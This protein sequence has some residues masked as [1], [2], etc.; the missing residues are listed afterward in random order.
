MLNRYRNYFTKNVRKYIEKNLY[1]LYPEK[2]I[3]RNLRN[4]SSQECERFRNSPIEYLSSKESL[5]IALYFSLGKEQTNFNEKVF[6]DVMD[7]FDYSLKLSTCPK[8]RHLIKLSIG[9]VLFEKGVHVEKERQRKYL[10]LAKYYLEESLATNQNEELLFIYLTLVEVSLGHLNVAIKN[11]TK[12]SKASENPL[13]IWR[14]LASI[15]KNLGMIS[16][17]DYFL[18]K[19]D[20][21]RMVNA[22]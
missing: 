1:E 21:Y 22:A 4:I 8:E 14:M 3:F 5:A 18:F 13:P 7:Y 15:Y 2:S 11:L 9:V 16:V 20:R 17:S 10:K 6:Q 12:A 19:I